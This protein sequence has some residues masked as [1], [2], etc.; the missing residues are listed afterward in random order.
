MMICI[1]LTAGKIYP[2]PSRPKGHRLEP[3]AT[4][5][6]SA[7]IATL[8]R[9]TF[10]GHFGMRRWFS[11]TTDL[12]INTQH[13]SITHL[14]NIMMTIIKNISIF[15]IAGFRPSDPHILLELIVFASKEGQL[16]P[17]LFAVLD[18]LVDLIPESHVL[19]LLGDEEALA[20]Y[21]VSYIFSS[22]CLISSLSLTLLSLK[23]CLASFSIPP[24]SFLSCAMSSNSCNIC[25][26]RLVVF[27]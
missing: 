13:P 23:V 8:T 2:R 5:Q 6:S 4:T 26:L 18:H 11:P 19:G 25:W 21:S 22:N 15:V 1:T 14:Y 3:R 16:R 27:F 17:D 7:V 24:R 20:K 10:P 12:Y 9:R